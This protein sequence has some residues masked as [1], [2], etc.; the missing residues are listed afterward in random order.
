MESLVTSCLAGLAL[1]WVAIP[2][3]YG[4]CGPLHISVCAMNRK[5]SL[6]ALTV[7]NIGRI[8]GYSFAGLLFGAFGEFINIGPS[9]WCCQLSVF[10][11]RG[12]MLALL[13]PGITMIL[14]GII[15]HYK[16]NMLTPKVSWLSK[17]FMGGK[18]KLATGGAC[19]TFIPCG[20]LYAAFAMSIG[21]GSWIGG[22]I[23]MFSFALTQTFFMQLGISIGRILNK[24][25]TNRI[26]SFFP[27]LCIILGV[28]YLIL[29]IIKIT[30]A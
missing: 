9:N 30:P 3:C 17:L 28:V 20:M 29:F 1:G 12:A 26:N 18:I 13:F 21:T 23:F 27:L 10:P 16:K 24:I 22:C 19:T 11:I 4:M 2:H 15:S 25:W 6:T 14:I 7:F 5:K 8:M